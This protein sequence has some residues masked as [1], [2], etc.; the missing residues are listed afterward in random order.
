MNKLRI[1]GGF[2]LVEMMLLLII[3]SLMIASGV[4]VITKKHVKVPKL[5]LH[6]AYICYYNKDGKLHEEKYVGAGTSRKIW[7]EN[8]DVCRFVPPER[9]SYFYVQAVAGGGAGGSAGYN[10][11]ANREV[12]WSETEVLS[13]FAFTNDLLALKGI[14]SGELTANG[15]TISAFAKGD[16]RYGDA[17]DGGDIYYIKKAS[18]T[19]FTYE[20]WYNPRKEPKKCSSNGAKDTFS[21][22]HYRCK[23]YY[24]SYYSSYGYSS[25]SGCSSGCY[26][27]CFDWDSYNYCSGGTYDS[28]CYSDVC[29][30]S[31][32]EYVCD[33]DG[34]C[35]WRYYCREGYDQRCYGCYKYYEGGQYQ[36]YEYD[37]NKPQDAT[38]TLNYSNVLYDNIFSYGVQ[39]PTSKT[40]PVVLL[41]QVGTMKDQYGK[42]EGRDAR[43]RTIV[44]DQADS[45]STCNYGNPSTYQGNNGIFGSCF[46]GL[47]CNFSCTTTG[48]S[49]AFGDGV[50]VLGGG[51][52]STGR[53]EEFSAK[54][55]WYK[56][57]KTQVNGKTYNGVY[58]DM[59]EDM[60]GIAAYGTLCNTGAY[61]D[62]HYNCTGYVSDPPSGAT[63]SPKDNQSNTSFKNPVTGTTYNRYKRTPTSCTIRDYTRSYNYNNTPSCTYRT[64]CTSETRYVSVLRNSSWTCEHDTS[65]D[66]Q[67]A[68]EYSSSQV[69]SS[70]R[71]TYVIEVASGEAGGVGQKCAFSSSAQ[72]GLQYKGISSILA[73]IDGSDLNTVGVYKAI[74]CANCANNWATWRNQPNAWAQD[75][76]DSEGDATVQLG[77]NTCEIHKSQKPT[78]GRGACLKNNGGNP[79]GYAGSNYTACEH[80]GEHPKNGS[81]AGVGKNADPPAGCGTGH[82][83]YCLNSRSNGLKPWGKY[84]Y[85]YSW[86]RNNLAYGNP[87]SPGEYR[88][89]VIRSFKDRELVLIPGLGGAIGGCSGGDG[90]D[91]IIYTIPKGSTMNT[92]PSNPTPT[93]VQNAVLDI[94]GN[95]LMLTVDGG[96]GG[97]GCIPTASEQLP[98]HFSY[99]YPRRGIVGGKGGYPTFDTKSNVMGLV[100]PLDDTVLGQWLKYSGA[101]GDGGGSQNN[102]WVSSWERYFEG[103]MVRGNVGYWREFEVPCLNDYYNIPPTRGIPGAVL[104]KW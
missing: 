96:S 37:Y 26:C 97:S 87:G 44:R 104:I 53:A 1:L 38:C 6:G 41:Q 70:R 94:D 59:S 95:E 83:G 55:P 8:V 49:N 14:N 2:S 68:C 78:R 81:F 35:R 62:G 29:T 67:S 5:A 76:T 72:A 51:S 24:K 33:D 28:P 20:H 57:V 7:D 88:S 42:G 52:T 23:N 80:Q 79:V 31:G 63:Q 101:A 27:S 64:D 4:S 39:S 30:W 61:K 11:I 13:P 60:G 66:D 47:D 19:C 22:T 46:V 84:T 25:C 54:D 93:D 85:K 32:S 75:G 74:F 12:V 15:G 91:T 50:L 43:V 21:Y 69:S 40:P 82:V 45:Y 65:L 71:Y 16:G 17:G 77:S 58:Y 34:Y 18:D 99:P 102:C 86:A 100:L 73:G 48:V 98:Y 90:G 9:A 103:T 36:V 89:M 92:L 56:G 3:V 10:G